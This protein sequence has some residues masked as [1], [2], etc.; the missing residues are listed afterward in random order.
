M[1]PLQPTAEVGTPGEIGRCSMTAIVQ[2]T[3]IPGLRDAGHPCHVIWT[4]DQGDLV[5]AQLTPAG[6]REL[7]RVH[8]IESTS[9]LFETNKFAWAAPVYAERHI[10]IRNDRELRCHSAEKRTNIAGRPKRRH[11]VIL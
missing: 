11:H 5:R 7:G 8:L 9:P 2:P 4:R 3:R 10:F 6:Y 1:A